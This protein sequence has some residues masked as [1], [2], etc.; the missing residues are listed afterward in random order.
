MYDLSGGMAKNLSLKIS[1][2]ASKISVAK[3]EEIVSFVP[4]DVI[5]KDINTNLDADQIRQ[6]FETVLEEHERNN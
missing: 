4:E 6:I 2:A 1:K 5:K 3:K